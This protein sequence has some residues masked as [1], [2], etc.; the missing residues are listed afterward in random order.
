MMKF[1]LN[2]FFINLIDRSFK[3]IEYCVGNFIK[4]IFLIYFVVK[5][6]KKLNII[7][8]MNICCFLYSE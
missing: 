3:E 7:S 5:I 2:K 4:I 6:F 8:E 1:I